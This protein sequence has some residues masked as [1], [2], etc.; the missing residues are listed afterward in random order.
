[1]DRLVVVERG[2]IVESGTHDELLRRGGIT[3]SCGA[4][5]RAASLPMTCFRPILPRTR[6]SVAAAL[7]LAV[8]ATAHAQQFE[9]AS[10]AQARDILGRQDAYVLSTA[11][12]EALFF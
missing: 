4:T 3:R 11:A 1:M 10:Q 12:R 7:V 6:P 2:K 9:F 8:A 5:S